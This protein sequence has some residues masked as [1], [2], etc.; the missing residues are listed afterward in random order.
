MAYC[1]VI[2][3]GPPFGKVMMR[4][5]GRPPSPCEVCGQ[6]RHTKLC[7]FPTGPGRTCSKKLC[8]ACTTHSAPDLDYC[9]DHK[10]GPQAMF[11]GPQSFI[12]VK[13]PSME[14]THTLACATSSNLKPPSSERI[15]LAV[16]KGNKTVSNA[17]G[18][19]WDIC[20]QCEGSG[21]NN[22]TK[23]GRPDMCKRCLGKGVYPAVRMGR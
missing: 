7:D 17:R 22:S 18:E 6:V 10:D 9:P 16:S 2:D 1:E 8:D 4:M 5:S 12:D 3:M 13:G 20:T 21:M 14:P 19:K 23:S 15:A 11:K